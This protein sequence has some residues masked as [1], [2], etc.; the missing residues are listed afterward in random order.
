LRLHANFAS[1]ASRST[2]VK[3]TTFEGRDRG[4]NIG[5]PPVEFNCAGRCPRVDTLP[6][7]RYPRIMSQSIEVIVNGE[8]LSIPSGTTV[9][10]LL[11][12]LNIRSQQ[13]AVEV[14]TQ[15]VK[16]AEHAEHQLVVGD[17]VEIVTFVGG[18]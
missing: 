8:P 15:L 6:L 14:N 7:R 3:L 10:A 17:Q 5:M 16:K 4:P 12:R 18:G 9:L 1:D 2:A 13:V 11:Q